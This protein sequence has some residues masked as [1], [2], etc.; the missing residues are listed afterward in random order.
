MN[1][2]KEIRL[3]AQTKTGRK[4]DVEAIVECSGETRATINGVKVSLEYDRVAKTMKEMCK[5]AFTLSTK[6]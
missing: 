6:P 5:L 1:K 2:N 3:T 4:F